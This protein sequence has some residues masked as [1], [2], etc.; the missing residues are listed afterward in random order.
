MDFGEYLLDGLLLLVCALAAFTD[1]RNHRIPDWLTLP[2]VG[3][4]LALRWA[5][6]GL[7]GAFDTGLV[8]AMFG[9]LVG[10]LVFGMFAVWGKGMGGGD[11]KLMTAVGS[12]AGFLHG[13]TCVMC[14]A[15]V[16]AVLALGLLIAKRK[17]LSTA[18]GFWRR[19]F[20]KPKD[21]EDR[22]TLPYG[23]PIA[24]G[25]VWATLIKHGILA[26]F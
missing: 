16:G 12:L 9:A 1:L 14:T 22:I 20:T 24:L 4:G 19:V 15:V 8:A 18:R 7:G 13:L 26:G 25:V 17:V 21:G 11:V 3:L 10:F 23:L 5:F 6:F 2:A